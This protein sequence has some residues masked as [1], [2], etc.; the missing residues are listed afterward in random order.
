MRKI[1]LNCAVAALATC[2][3]AAPALAMIIVT[4]GPAFTMSE[5]GVTF[6]AVRKREHR[7]Y[8]HDGCE[9]RC[10]PRQTDEGEVT[11]TARRCY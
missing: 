4:R 8:R 5:R 1:N 3:F 7:R 2:S 10:A 11:R 9:T 6:G